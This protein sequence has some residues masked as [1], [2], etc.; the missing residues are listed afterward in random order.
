MSLLGLDGGAIVSAWERTYVRLVEGEGHTKEQTLVPQR[1]PEYAYDI[2]F[3][4]D[5]G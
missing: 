3:L 1:S 4:L 2:V 5:N